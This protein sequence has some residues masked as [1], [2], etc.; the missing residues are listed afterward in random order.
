MLENLLSKAKNGDMEAQ[1]K[2][3]ECY[4]TGYDVKQNYEETVKWYTKAAK[5]EYP[6]AQL[7]LGICYFNGEGVNKNFVEAKYAYIINDAL[8]SCSCL[9][10]LLTNNSQNSQFVEKEVERAVAY[11]KS[12]IT[13]YAARKC[14]F[15]FWF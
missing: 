3:G 7:M 15:K 4:S 10:L 2:L 11:K 13:Y 1:Y 6:F 12:I 5:Q 14:C 8:E 9:L